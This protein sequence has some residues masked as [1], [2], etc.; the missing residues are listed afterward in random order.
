MKKTFYFNTG[1][2]P[3]GC[4][5]PPYKLSNGHIIRGG[6]VQIPFDCENVPENASFMFACDNP[7]LSESKQKNVIVRKM[8]NTVMCSEYAYFKIFT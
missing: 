8:Y 2:K 5:N 3:Y 7:E 1:V 6:V 4:T